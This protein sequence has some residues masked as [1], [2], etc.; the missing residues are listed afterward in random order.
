MRLVFGQDAMERNVYCEGFDAPP[1]AGVRQSSKSF[2]ALSWEARNVCQKLSGRLQVV[3]SKGGRGLSRSTTQSGL[4]LCVGLFIVLFLCRSIFGSQ[5]PPPL[6]LKRAPNT[7]LRM[8]M[9]LG[10]PNSLPP[11][12]AET[13]AFS[14]L[15][16]LIPNAGIVPYDVNVPLWSDGAHKTRWFSLP[17][18]NRT[19]GFEREKSW[20]FPTGTIWVK[21]FELE[22]TNGVP[23]S[24]RRIETR[25]LI[26][27]A[28]GVYGVTYRWD[29]SQTNATLVE[30]EGL[31]EDI[32]IQDDQGET[33]TQ[34]WR[35]PSRD[36]CLK[37]HTPAA[38]W[39]LGFNTWQLNRDSNYDGVTNNQIAALNQAGY[40]STNVT[41]IH[42]LRTLAAATNKA[43]SLEY[44][45]RSYLAANCAQCHQPGTECLARWDAR[46]TTPTDR[47]GIING[48]LVFPRVSNPTDRVVVPGSL[49]HSMMFNRISSLNSFHMPPLATTVLNSEAINLLS[50]WITNG[51]AGYQSFADWQ[52]AFFKSTQ[53]PGAAPDADPDGDGAVNQLEYLV[54]SN[55]LVT[56][57]AWR[58]NIQGVAS[59]V[60]ISFA[61]LANRAFDLQWT[62]NLFYTTPWVSLD[63]PDNR[64]F[65]AATNSET[66]IEDSIL[67]ST[68][69]FYR[70][71][72][73]DP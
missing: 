1:G 55:P 43:W 67:P 6:A 54:G 48:S 26:R 47:S 51:L 5:A 38:G 41:G 42:T 70:V 73:Y 37:C 7:S 56:G 9:T 60:R 34:V 45:V 39:A 64:P 20:T 15:I 22:L 57:D 46:I 53:V 40:F 27:N 61:R 31:D 21:H 59:S 66:I 52:L 36:E 25:F 62:T 35:Y 24:A 63:H 10:D 49:E 23:T 2:G 69:R 14:D 13:G 65:F 72:I 68:P 16:N 28:G 44:Q 18:T 50:E 58:F 4:K 12:L 33:H 19:I 32:D 3:V 17:D 30:K 8:P 71:R 11:T 29:E